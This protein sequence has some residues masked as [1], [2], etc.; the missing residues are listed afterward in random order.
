MFSRYNKINDSVSLIEKENIKEDKEYDFKPKKYNIYNIKEDI[1]EYD[2]KPKKYD[3]YKIKDF[4]VIGFNNS[5]SIINNFC[6]AS[7]LSNF[8]NCPNGIIIYVPEHGAIKFKNAEAAFQAV[9]YHEE[10]K[11]FIK[12]SGFEVIRLEN[13]LKNIYPERYGS[14]ELMFEILIAKFRQNPNLGKILCE[15]GD[16]FLIEHSYRDN[17]WSNNGD[18]T[19]SNILGLLLMK[20]RYIINIEITM[21][22]KYPIKALQSNQYMDLPPPFTN[23]NVKEFILK[24]T[25]GILNIIKQK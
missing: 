8:I 11:L 7:C 6:N 2:F 15:S 20:V 23:I 1:E 4:H 21:N 24:A 10:A 17:R 13:K 12:L 14:P 9:K 22:K 16:A 19:G 25:D 18:G 3:I 5:N